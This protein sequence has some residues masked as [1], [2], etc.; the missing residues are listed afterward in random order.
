MKLS[1][2]IQSHMEAI[3][4]EWD[5][6][7]RAS[8]PDQGTMSDEAL[9]DH[10]RAMLL[11]IAREMDTAQSES[12]RK[13]KSEGL[14]S[15]S[16]NEESAAS[17]HGRERH[18]N[19]F[20]LATLSA[21]F[22]ALRATVLRLWQ[23]HMEQAD[24]SA[25]E[26]V[27]RFSE[28]I[29]KALAESISAWSDRTSRLREMFLAILGHDLRS[30][31]A[32]VAL[33]ADMLAQPG[34]SA[35]KVHT[36]ALNVTRATGVMTHMIDDLMGYASNQLGGSMPHHPESCDLLAA[37][38]DALKDAGATYPEAHFQLHAPAALV[39][40]YDPIRLYQMFLNLLVNAARYSKDDG[41][42]TV[43]AGSSSGCHQVSITNRGET[44]PQASLKSIFK[45]LVQLDQGDAHLR[46]P[47]TSLGLG[48]YIAR[49]IAERHGG[50]IEVTSDDAEG[51]RFSVRLPGATE[52]QAP[53]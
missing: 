46:R 3:L 52:G 25:L 16:S 51:T 8:E 45:P 2:F 47:R 12:E 11:D 10:A 40:C 36:L 28:G 26:Q 27:I 23:S 14:E 9:R 42:V 24:A 44:I 38:R 21:E 5:A 41:P 49:T 30:P 6:F 37:L 29:D 33:A 1:S 20:T 48:L 7:A 18:S 19:D 22:R 17:R 15:Q 43:E 53:G 13:L 4:T 39:G 31:L 34:V 35:A 32:S 50:S